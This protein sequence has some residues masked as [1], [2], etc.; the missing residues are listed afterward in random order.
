MRMTSWMYG[1]TA[2]CCTA[3]V[4]G[5]VVTSVPTANTSVTVRAMACISVMAM[6]NCCYAI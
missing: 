4:N 2:I 3:I 5:C 6:G 1:R